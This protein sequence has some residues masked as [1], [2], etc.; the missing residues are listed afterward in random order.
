M[1]ITVKVKTQARHTNTVLIRGQKDLINEMNA[2]R[3]E[4]LAKYY[5]EY[6][7]QLEEIENLY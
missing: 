4:L 2:S 3:K 1:M 5:E 6:Q 7:K